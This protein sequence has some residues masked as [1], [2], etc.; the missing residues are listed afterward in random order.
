MSLQRV[1]RV[2]SIKEVWAVL[3]V[4]IVDVL[5]ALFTIEGHLEIYGIRVPIFDNKRHHSLIQR[6]TFGGKKDG[7]VSTCASLVL[8]A[9]HLIPT[10]DSQPAATSFEHDPS[11]GKA[12]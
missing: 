2:K 1:K 4:T 9:P 7:M 5:S 3:T 12:S 10:A 8:Y 6:P 11:S